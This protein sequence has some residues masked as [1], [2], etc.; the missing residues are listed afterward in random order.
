MHVPMEMLL[1][2]AGLKMTHV[3]YT[4]AGPAIVG[5]ARRQYR[6]VATG[7]ATIVQHISAGKVRALAQ[8]GNA[9][10]V[11]LPDVPTLQE[12]GTDVEYAQ[13]SGLFVPAD[14]P[15]AA[16]SACATPRAWRRTTSASRR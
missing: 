16:V 12:L 4:G 1:A 7:P 14:T 2:A 11:A 10:L 8:W 13:W 15:D 9:R 3:P 6:R 5:A